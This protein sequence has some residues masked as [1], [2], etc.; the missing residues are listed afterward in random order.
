MIR[1]SD[2]RRSVDRDDRGSEDSQDAH[3]EEAGTPSDGEPQESPPRPFYKRLTVMVPLMVVLCG[4]LA[5]GVLY[6][7]HARHY[8]STDDA[9]IDGRVT[10]INPKVAG[11]VSSLLVD[12]NQLVKA[13]ELLLEIDPRDFEAAL[14]EARAGLDQARAQV[15][16][17]Q[18]QIAL[19]EA[20]EKSAE[21]DVRAAEAVAMNAQQVLDRAL[22]AETTLTGSVP[23]Q[24]IDQDRANV[25]SSAAAL[26][27]ARDKVIESK[28]RTAAARS[29]LVTAQAKVREDQAAVHAAELKLSYTKLV[30]PVTGRVTHRSVEKGDYLEAGQA[31]FALVQPHLWVTA[32]FK[33]TQLTN[34]RVGQPVLV[35]V[36]A[37][38][39]FDLK[40]HV[41]SFQRGTGAQFSLLPP[42]NAT[43][44]Y[45]KVV[46]R[47]PVK[48]E[49]DEPPPRDIVLGPGMSVV[50]RVTVR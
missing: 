33:E 26:A 8:V 43:G 30:A 42:E 28:A 38:P 12:D 37:Y 46:Q 45:V 50:P 25:R 1:R 4:G 7:L 3:E 20:M 21:A 23:A 11:Y 27:S 36:D 40:A 48:I 44:N 47:V 15:K 10:Q 16:Q 17:A 18:S 5:V 22:A 13:G 41:D 2:T 31:L 14:S 29:D 39:D 49:F 32:N 24:E 34:M 6:W 35:R 19:A 9:F